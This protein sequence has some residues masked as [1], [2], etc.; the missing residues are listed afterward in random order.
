MFR[1]ITELVLRSKKGCD[2]QPLALL[3]FRTGYS[4]YLFVL[5][6]ALLYTR[7]KI[8]AKYQ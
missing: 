6:M 1:S 4:L 8:C 5:Q 2:T 7:N 3:F